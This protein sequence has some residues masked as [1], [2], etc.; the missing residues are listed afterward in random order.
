MLHF[1]SLNTLNEEGTLSSSEQSLLSASNS[2]GKLADS[3]AYR[4][5]VEALVREGESVNDNMH[6]FC[7]TGIVFESQQRFARQK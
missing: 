7:S 5:G 3:S 6:A 1:M 4:A 2:D